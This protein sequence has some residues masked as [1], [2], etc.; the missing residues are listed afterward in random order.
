MSTI[1][2]KP[3]LFSAPMVKAILS[4]KKTMTRRVI[5]PRPSAFCKPFNVRVDDE[6]FIWSGNQHGEIRRTKPSP[7]GIVG[8][9]LWIRETWRPCLTGGV[10]IEYRVGGRKE[11]NDDSDL[12]NKIVCETMPVRSIDVKDE[13]RR[14]AGEKHVPYVWRPSIFMKRWASRITLEITGVRVERLHS[15]TA[16]D[17]IAEGVVDRPHKVEGLEGDC[18]VS[19]VDGACYMDLRSLWAAAWTKINGKESWASNPFVWVI[20]F[21]RVTP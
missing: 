20:E 14:K 8:D 13:E 5:M 10:S 19:A 9:H 11:A 12:H 21:K 6:G 16:K 2:E 4:G 17:I 18:P 7:Y 15:I 1:K 3:I